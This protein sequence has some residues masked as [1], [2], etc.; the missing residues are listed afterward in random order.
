MK[1]H[2]LMAIAA[3]SSVAMAQ[4]ADDAISL[5]IHP[6]NL[7]TLTLA[8]GVITPP[9][10]AG[11]QLATPGVIYD[12][13]CLPYAVAPCNTIFVNSLPLGQT[14][15]DDGRLPSTT[16]TT[17][18]IGTMNAYRVTNF[19]LGVYTSEDD[20]SIGGPGLRL[21]VMFWEDADPCVGLTVA[22]P[23]TKTL[24]LVLPGT[25]TTGTVRGYFININLAGGNEFT[26]K[27]DANGSYD[28]TAALDD[29]AYA[30]QVNLLTAGKLC[31]IMRAGQP[32]GGS[33]ACSMGDGTYY[34][35]PG[36][37][38]GNGL[39]DGNTY[40]IEGGGATTGCYAGAA[41][42]TNCPTQPG[43]VY[44]AYYMEITAD[45]TDC[46]AN[47]LPDFDDIAAGA[48]D[49]NANG[50]PDSCETPQPFNYCTAGTTTN[51]C[52]A[53][54]SA[55]GT[56]SAAATSGFTLTCSQAEGLKQ[57]IIF[58][59]NLG[60]A[61]V[62]WVNGLGQGNSFLCVKAPTQRT[63]AVTMGGTLNL[64]DGSMSVDFLA[65][66]AANPGAI[67][68]PLAA[69]QTFNSQA[70]FRDPPSPKTTNLSDGLQWTM[71]P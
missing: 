17:P 51:G 26:M 55:T 63:G 47:G 44:G 28:G 16:S 29:F 58:Y 39:D 48:P 67:G 42:Q 22:G 46:N 70:W 61:A 14:R 6:E 12:N 62:P 9:A 38:A 60:Q 53:S 65:Y 4:S 71:V 35:N 1:L 3:L 24:N 21:T 68:N 54:M 2:Q 45:M 20:P 52:L 32:A 59:G 57:G 33:G 18:N 37:A 34:L 49:T 40:W 27:A 23:A 64:C 41:T 11:S 13:T 15:I 31:Y 25:L 7:G 69:G 56:P 30:F 50:I 19:T 43:P 10:P 66:C 8:T 5:P 36:T